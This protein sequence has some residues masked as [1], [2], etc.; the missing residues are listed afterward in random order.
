MAIIRIAQAQINTT[1]GDFS[2]NTSKIINYIDM[3]RNQNADIVTFPELTVCGY[4]PEDLLLKPRF[5]EDNR[6]AVEHIRPHIEN[7][8]VV[9]GYADSSETRS[10]MLQH[11]SKTKS[12]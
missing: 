7:M 4:P 3:A 12:L 5:L 6:E 9:I 1:V 8:A 10:I 11:S 2:A